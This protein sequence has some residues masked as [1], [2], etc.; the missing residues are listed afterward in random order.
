MARWHLVIDVE[1]CEDCNNCFLACKDEHVD[2]EWPG[3]AAA[4]PRHGQRWI[5]IRRRERGGYPLV[6]AVYLP[7]PCMHCDDA[8]CVAAGGGAVRKRPDGIVLIDPERTK[9]DRALV[10]SCPYGAIWW[11]EERRLPQKCT[12]CAHLLDAGWRDTRCTQACPTGALR[13][14]DAGQEE[15]AS[16]VRV[17]SLEAL[18]PQHGTAPRVLYRNLSRWRSDLVCGSVTLEREGVLECA[19]GA[20]VELLNGREAGGPHARG[21]APPPLAVATTDAFGD[22]RL[23]G[24]EPGPGDYSIVVR[25]DGYAE[26][27]A[28]LDTVGGYN[29]GTIHLEEVAS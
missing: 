27:T 18:D 10:A 26:A 12:L 8:P 22:F 6:D 21:P 1:R 7:V 17:Q 9:G 2:N 14:V 11:D 28:R 29:V 16:M 13:L 4:Q 20:V 25:L 23:D 24:L 5:D 15:M 19:V 3:Y